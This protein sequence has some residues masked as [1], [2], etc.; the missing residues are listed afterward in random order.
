MS[1][2]KVGSWI[3]EHLQGPKELLRI[4]SNILWALALAMLAGADL[5][6][7]GLHPPVPWWVVLILA[8]AAWWVTMKISERQEAQKAA[9][10]LPSE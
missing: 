6:R 7:I 2:E 3:L 5:E 9:G 10:V 4:V 1:A 8:V